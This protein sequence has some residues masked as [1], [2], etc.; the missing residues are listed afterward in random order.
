MKQPK[1]KS[2]A[3]VLS[4]MTEIIDTDTPVL[5]RRLPI[6]KGN[7]GGNKSRL[8]QN[9]WF[10]AIFELNEIRH[11][12]KEYN[13]VL[14]DKQILH[15]WTQEYDKNAQFNGTLIRGGGISSGKITIG[16]YRNK[17]RKGIIHAG[18]IKPI[19]M[20]FRYSRDANPRRDGNSLRMLNLEQIRQNCLQYR[21][22]DPRFFT[23]QEIFD[24]KE[25]AMRTGDIRSWG[26]PSEF[27]W[28]ELD[29]QVPGGIYGSYS[30]FNAKY[31]ADYSPPRDD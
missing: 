4:M 10:K 9:L 5:D 11:L 23:V 20:S 6:A 26:I 14:N 22:A 21:I 12:R 3:D 8:P 2:H 17:Y 1:Y 30:I 7:Y 27:Q 29:K 18:Q 13:K 15:N 25:H 19:L 28:E 24:I 16:Q 31:G